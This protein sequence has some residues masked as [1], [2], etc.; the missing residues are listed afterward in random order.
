MELSYRIEYDGDY[1]VILI[2]YGQRLIVEDIVLGFDTTKEYFENYVQNLRVDNM[3]AFGVS[4]WWI[5][6]M[7]GLVFDGVHESQKEAM[8]KLD[9]LKLVLENQ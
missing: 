3:N 6:D 1:E 9:S 8:N 4:E 7:N 2:F 5:A